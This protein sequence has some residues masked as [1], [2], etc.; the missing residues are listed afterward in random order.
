MPDAYVPIRMATKHLTFFLMEDIVY[1]TCKTDYD[2]SKPSTA[3]SRILQFK[4]KVEFGK[5][6][7]CLFSILFSICYDLKMPAIMVLDVFASI[8]GY[9]AL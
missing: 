6:V 5:S 2:L 9:H 1:Q 4:W 7:T 3:L 8:D